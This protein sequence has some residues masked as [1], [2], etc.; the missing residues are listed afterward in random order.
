MAN[1]VSLGGIFG[2]EELAVTKG[3][4]PDESPPPPVPPPPVFPI[5][6]QGGGKSNAGGIGGGPNGIFG[7]TVPSCLYEAPGRWF[8]WKSP[9]QTFKDWCDRRAREEAEEAEEVEEATLL[10]EADPPEA[11]VCEVPTPPEAP[12][13]PPPAPP[14]PPRSPE[15]PLAAAPA[16]PPPPPAG[17][18]WRP[19]LVALG[20]AA[21]V[22]GGIY[23]V[24]RF[25]KPA[26]GG[27]H[28]A[29]NP[30]DVGPEPRAARA[31][32]PRR[33]ANP[34]GPITRATMRALRGPPARGAA[35]TPRAPRL[36]PAR[37]TE[38]RAIEAAPQADHFANE[39]R[40]RFH[41]EEDARAYL[42]AVRWPRGAVCPHCA[43]ADARPIE[44]NIE[45]RVRGG[46]YRCG[47]CSKQYTVTVGTVF[48]GSHVTLSQWL[49]ALYL[50]GAHGE[51]VSTKALQAELGLGSY[52]SAR[53]VRSRLKSA[54]DGHRARTLDGL[55]R[56][57]L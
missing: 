2:L 30:I 48:E 18:W 19:A 28:F 46:L 13:T 15:P 40:R 34:V 25:A 56:R 24:T 11:P 8:A 53:L 47:G 49:V 37:S 5:P 10:V 6:I 45:A 44:E 16:P 31:T 43:S 29:N 9:Q 17:P 3:L 32:P 50:L 26:P 7:F 54:L 41:S 33:S 55:V 35:R 4:G 57:V 14:K 51:A 27:G 20:G 52:R 38:A 22:G 36:P 23:A 39:V 21:L 1:V 42:E 12:P